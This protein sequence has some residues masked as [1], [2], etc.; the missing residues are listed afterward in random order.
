MEV[1]IKYLK[2]E[3]IRSGAICR[4]MELTVGV[5]SHELNF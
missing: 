4:N 1:I 2:M 3:E 5:F